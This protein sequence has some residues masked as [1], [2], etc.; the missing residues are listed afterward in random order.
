MNA[1]PT[2]PSGPRRWT[3]PTTPTPRRAPRR[4]PPRGTPG[5]LA[6]KPMNIIRAAN[7]VLPIAPYPG[8]TLAWIAANDPRLLRWLAT[9]V[10]SGSIRRAAAY[11]HMATTG[12][13]VGGVAR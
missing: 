12:E 3:P 2:P 1:Y 9:T 13:I 8:R 6:P 4:I 10:S 7:F 5:N 11:L